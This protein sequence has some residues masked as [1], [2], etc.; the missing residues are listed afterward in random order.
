MSIRFPFRRATDIRLIVGALLRQ[1]EA[2]WTGLCCPLAQALVRNR[3][4]HATVPGLQRRHLLRHRRHEPH[5]IQVFDPREADPD[6]WGDLELVDCETDLAMKVTVSER[7]LRQYKELYRE[8]QESVQHYCRHHSLGST[9]TPTDIPF[10]RLIL[11]MM[12][13]AGQLV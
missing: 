10:D 2:G 13:S 5:L 12:R 6:L 11:Q 3:D 1:T 9:R 7:S 4:R 8:F